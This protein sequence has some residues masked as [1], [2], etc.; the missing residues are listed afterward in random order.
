MKHPA[1]IVALLA[2]LALPAS[3]AEDLDYQL[4]TAAALADLC[5][6]PENVSAIH[7]C[8][9]FL[10]GVHQMHEAIAATAKDRIYCIPEENE[11]SRN[12]VAA[13][14]SAW[15]NERPSVAAKGAYDGALT[16]AKTR[17]P[18]N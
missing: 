5:D 14:L 7:M 4:D 16:W 2:A 3:A 13:E 1:C 6:E 15:I 11:L 10:V 18:C 12:Q 8:V 9:G 17:F